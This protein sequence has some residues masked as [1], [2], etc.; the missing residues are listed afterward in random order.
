MPHPDPI[1]A[2]TS[3]RRPPA[4]LLLM[5][6]TAASALS[7]LYACL[8]GSIPLTTSAIWQSLSGNDDGL[9]ATLLGLR[10]DRALVAWSTGASLALAG[11]L[12]QSLLRNPLADPYVLGVSGGAAVGALTAL[13]LGLASWLVDSAAAAGALIIS[14][15]LFLL[16]RRDFGRSS[17]TVLLLL[18]GVLLATASGALISL[19]LTI[20]PEGKLRGMVF[21]LV[22]DLAGTPLQPWPWLV[23]ALALPLALWRA[24]A[25]NLLALHGDHADTLGVNVAPLRRVLLL[26]AAMLTASAVS[27]GGSIGFVGL[28]V[29]HA[30]RLICGQNL[31]VL[32]PAS[33]LAGSALLVTADTLARTVVAPMQLPVGVITALIGVPVMFWQLNRARRRLA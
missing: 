19:L 7:L 32:I 5:A 18:T 28:L 31:R 13:W 21:W 14:A 29:P 6:L 24:P 20:A 30:C 27:M 2:A 17:A 4:F 1:S 3:P 23:L 26:L 11:L 16:A 10:L 22:G 15:M 33:V 12:I 9:T 8:S 25:I